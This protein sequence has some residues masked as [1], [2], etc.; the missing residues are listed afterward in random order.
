M[1]INLTDNNIGKSEGCIYPRNQIPALFSIADKPLRDLCREN[2]NLLVFPHSIDESDDR[3]GESS[4]ISLINTDNP[5][6]VRIQT[7]NIMGFIG[8]GDT[9]VKIHSRFDDGRQDFLLHYMMQKVISLNVFELNHN[10][11][12]ENI[13]EMTIFLL[14]IFL[15]AALHQGVYK[16][17]QWSRYN[18]ANIKGV[19]DMPRHIRDN[20]AFQGRVAYATREY[21]YDNSMTQLIRHTIEFVKTKRYGDAVLNID[22]ETTENVS[23]ISTYTPTYNRQER[24]KVIQQNLRGKIQPYFTEYIP[25]QSLCLQILR[26]ENMK[27]GDNENEIYGILFDGAWLW[28]EYLN[29]ILCRYGF[30]HPMNKIGKGAIYLFKDEERDKTILSGR[31]Y[32]D[33]YKRD[34][35]LDAKYKHLGNYDKVSLVGRDDI[36]QMIAYMNALKATKGGFIAPLT[37]HL[38]TPPTSRLKDSDSTISIFGIEISKEPEQYDL[39]CSSMTDNEKRFI[40]QLSNIMQTNDHQIRNYDLVLDAKFGSS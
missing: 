13:L 2:K 38:P 5:D 27:Y 21:S 16:E 37:R 26:T 31:R 17:Y 36:H 39:F 3:V 1:N 9:K 12:E 25:L 24:A 6:M 7:S 4:I 11:E 22:T 30:S 15:K 10:T 19:V 34:F 20:T 18:D 8:I 14:P 23:T 33:F 29:T 32:P 40:E 28:E 35:V